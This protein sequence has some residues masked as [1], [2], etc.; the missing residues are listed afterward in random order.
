MLMFLV[1]CGL[2]IV[3][4]YVL[5][6]AI[7]LVIMPFRWFFGWVG[8]RIMAA[9]RRRASQVAPKARAGFPAQTAHQAHTAP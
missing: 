8:R 1:W 5:A 7:A 4:L 2:G 9:K 3:L 6:A